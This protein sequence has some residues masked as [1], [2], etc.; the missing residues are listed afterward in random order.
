[1]SRDLQVVVGLC[2]GEQRCMVPVSH[3]VFSEDPCKNIAKYLEV[4]YRCRP[5][6]ITSELSLLSYVY[7][8]LTPTGTAIKHP[9]PDRVKPSFVIFD[10]R[11]L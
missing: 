3:H 9:V 1:M 10:I 8:P 11:T 6:N 7:N 5:G 2:D 4:A